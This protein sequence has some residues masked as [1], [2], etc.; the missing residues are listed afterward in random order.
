MPDLIGSV[1]DSVSEDGAAISLYSEEDESSVCLSSI[2]I[3][4]C[5]VLV[6][7]EDISTFLSL[8]S[9]LRLG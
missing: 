8:T 5:A 4:S 6:Y 1:F 7:E 2:V 9:R 3:F